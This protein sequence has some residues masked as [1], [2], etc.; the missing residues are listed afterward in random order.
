M[1]T[2]IT[3]GNDESFALSVPMDFKNSNVECLEETT[4]RQTGVDSSFPGKVPGQSRKN[5][6]VMASTG[7]NSGS[8]KPYVEDTCDPIPFKNVHHCIQLSRSMTFLCQDNA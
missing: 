5:E 1:K 6:V 8:W 3:D 7:D 2:P 4:I